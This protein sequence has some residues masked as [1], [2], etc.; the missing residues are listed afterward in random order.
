MPAEELR[1][2]EWPVVK[3]SGEF[4]PSERQYRDDVCHGRPRLLLS[5]EKPMNQS[6]L[7]FVGIDWGTEKHSVCVLDREGNKV[8]ECPSTA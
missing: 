1:P 8:A 5:K 4:A 3:S 7:F 6:F 2:G